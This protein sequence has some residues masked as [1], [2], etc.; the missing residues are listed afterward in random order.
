MKCVGTHQWLKVHMV[1]TTFY[2]IVSY[3]HEHPRTR[4]KHHHFR[5]FFKLV[6]TVSGE[7]Q[8]GW[9]ANGGLLRIY[10]INPEL[11]LQPLY[12]IA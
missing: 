3:L 1:T 12:Y 9:M 10:I 6:L 7:F 4:I 11:N 5:F 2:I 8:H